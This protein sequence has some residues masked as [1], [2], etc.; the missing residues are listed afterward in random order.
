MREIDHLQP[1]QWTHDPRIASRF[2]G[3]KAW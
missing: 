3:D 1:G 2:V